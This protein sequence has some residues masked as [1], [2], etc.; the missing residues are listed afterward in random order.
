[1]VISVFEN[2]LPAAKKVQGVDIF[3]KLS[4]GD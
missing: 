2:Q 4:G 1:M 3:Y